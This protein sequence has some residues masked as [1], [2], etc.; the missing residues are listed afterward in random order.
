MSYQFHVGMQVVCVFD[1]WIDPRGAAT[2][3]NGLV[4]TV[5]EIVDAA[6][7][8]GLRFEEI[9]NPVLDHDEGVME[10]DFD[11]RAFRP[12]RT[13]SIE[14]FERLLAPSPKERETCP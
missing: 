10:C 1:S 4:Y 2:P 8:L 13:T 9:V 3:K 12:V 5:R 14:V 7:W 6:P 11:A